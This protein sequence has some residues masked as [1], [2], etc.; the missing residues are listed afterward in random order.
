[1]TRSI[2][3]I[4]LIGVWATAASARADDADG[5]AKEV[6]AFAKGQLGK[7]VGNGQCAVLVIEALKAAGAKTTVDYGV[8]GPGKD[9]IWGTE[10]KK[11]PDVK[12]G[13]IVQFRD[14]KIVNR[15]GGRI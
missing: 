14:V 7:Q 9:Y 12:P 2:L 13:D 8:N 4:F 6:L 5:V 3:Q 1:M 10:V 11:Y 15:M